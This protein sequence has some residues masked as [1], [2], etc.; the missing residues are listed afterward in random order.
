MCPVAGLVSSVN[1]L[2]MCVI[3]IN[4]KL[5]HFDLDT[6]LNELL[7][8][9]G[10]LARKFANDAGCQLPMLELEAGVLAIRKQEFAHVIKDDAETLRA[11]II[12]ID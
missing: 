4:L 8:V 6:T 5:L 7:E 3:V 9:A 11:K 1:F 2:G 12:Q 10:V